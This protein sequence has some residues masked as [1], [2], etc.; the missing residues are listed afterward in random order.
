MVE[1]DASEL[2]QW[3]EIVSSSHRQLA[4]EGVFDATLLERMERLL[5]DYREGRAVTSP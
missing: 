5:K 3:R 2:S 4:R 1:P